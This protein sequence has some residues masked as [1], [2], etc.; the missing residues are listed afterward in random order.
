MLLLRA[1]PWEVGM[2]QKIDLASLDPKKPWDGDLFQ[3]E[4]FGK[5]LC[6]L[7]KASLQSSVIGLNAPYGFGK[8]YFLL[9]LRE[10]IK[11]ETG[12]VVYV[13]AWEYD[14]LEDPLFALLDALKVAAGELQNSKAIT[15]TLKEIGKA[16]APAI[17]K[18][19]VKKVF[20]KVVG[21]EGSKDIMDAISEASGKATEA[22]VA[23]YLKES[24]TNSTLSVL[25]D[26]IRKFVADHL[27]RNSQYQNLIFIVDELDRAKPSFAIRFL[28]T[29][30]HLFGLS[31]AT[32]II[33]C[34]RQVLESSAQ[35]EYG[36]GLPTDGYLRRLFDFWIELPPPK[37]KQY[38]IYCAEKL[39]LFADGVFTKDRST[40]TSIDTYAD[41]LLPGR[42]SQFCS[43][44]FIE[45]SVAHAGAV[46]R[47]LGGQRAAPLIGWLQGL[48]YDAPEIWSL[49]SSNARISEVYR[50]LASYS[51]FFDESEFYKSLILLWLANGR[52]PVSGQAFRHLIGEPLH[53]AMTQ[54]ASDFHFD[55]DERESWAAVM[56]R[57][58][59]S[60]TIRI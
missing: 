40:W 2:F 41:L 21:A 25:R 38:V 9:R 33:G 23:Q 11:S 4:E 36:L 59:Q 22:M 42:K 15:S 44:R 35:H 24:T 16:A 13:N 7:L 3:R 19:G 60:V 50:K 28:E 39:G 27:D 58:L 37:P 49:V 30:K 31:Q 48:Q 10:Q 56:S 57:K 54:R 6:Q 29:I 12:W 43:L 46:M 26:E 55:L 17:A 47:M 53:V 52:E 45:Q 1:Q 32:F 51:P 14:Y 5:D 34:D 18:A 8:T 20:E